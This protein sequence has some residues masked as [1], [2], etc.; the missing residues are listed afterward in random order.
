MKKKHSWLKD[1]KKILASLICVI[2]FLLSLDYWGWEKSEPLFLG[3]P[4][5]I[6]YLF[7]LTLLTSVLFY[8]IT[9]NIWI[10][11]K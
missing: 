1:Q 3:L 2:L 5:W 11:K 8:F 10:E 9:K 4:I 6:Y 7:I